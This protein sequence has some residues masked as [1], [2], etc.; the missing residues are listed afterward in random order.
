MS[1]ALG[2]LTQ[3]IIYAFQEPMT[4]SFIKSLL[5]FLQ[6]SK[7]S[8]T[9]LCGRNDGN[10]KVI[11]PDVEMEDATNSGLRVRAQ[12]GDYVLVKVGCPFGLLVCTVKWGVA[13]DNLREQIFFPREIL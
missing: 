11:F 4:H 10:L 5:F 6:L 1:K 8:A 12:P 9:D 2:G 3:S 7:R 13:L